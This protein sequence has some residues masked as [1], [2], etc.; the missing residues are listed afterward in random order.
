MELKE[1]QVSFATGGF[2]AALPPSIKAR[3]NVVNE[4]D[5]V[6]QILIAGVGAFHRTPREEDRN[7]VA[8]G[9]QE[10]GTGISKTGGLFDQRALIDRVLVRNAEN[11][12]KSLG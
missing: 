2:G 12:I 9:V 11:H 5:A 6:V 8:D 1:L 7:L 4:S 3:G 10:S